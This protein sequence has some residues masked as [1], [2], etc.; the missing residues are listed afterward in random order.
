MFKQ[1]DND[2]QLYIVLSGAI[3]V[4]KHSHLMELG[5]I[6]PGEL[7]GEGAFINNRERSTS[8]RAKTDT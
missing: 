2:K 4:F 7:I 8:T 3:V 5:T 1:L 6:E